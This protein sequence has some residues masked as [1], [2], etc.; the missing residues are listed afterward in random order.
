LVLFSE[1][2]SYKTNVSLVIL[3]KKKK[4]IIWLGHVLVAAHRI[5][6]LSSYSVEP[7]ACGIEDATSRQG[8]NPHL[9]R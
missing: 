9:L 7:M 3:L 5:Q 8:L 1:T 2:V 4:K 6:G